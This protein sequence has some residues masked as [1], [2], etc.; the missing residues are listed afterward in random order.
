[1]AAQPL[2]L[3]YYEDVEPGRKKR[4]PRNHPRMPGSWEQYSVGIAPEP[5]RPE[6]SPVPSR[7]QNIPHEIA[8]QPVMNVAAP[9]IGSSAVLTEID[10]LAAGV[11]DEVKPSEYAYGRARAFVEA[12][13]G[14]AL[15]PKSVPRTIPAP[16]V[17]TD[18]V[19]G[20]RLAWRLGPKQLRANFGANANLRN[21]L[22][23]ESGLEHHV[24]DLDVSR[25]AGGLDWLAKK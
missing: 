23:F 2:P 4:A 22:Y 17:T 11:D 21:Y 25:L 8:V 18:D 5:L 9:F 1:M 15:L 7:D 12:A 6:F 13:Y 19:G 3:G 14:Q 16:L 24:E 10:A 20:V